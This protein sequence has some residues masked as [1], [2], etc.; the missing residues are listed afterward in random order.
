MHMIKG[1]VG[2]K[3]HMDHLTD[4]EIRHFKFDLEQ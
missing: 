3:A 1:P 4:T 2:H